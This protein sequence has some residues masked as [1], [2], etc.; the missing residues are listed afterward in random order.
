MRHPHGL[1]CRDCMYWK[2]DFGIWTMTGWT[3]MG[4]DAGHCYLEPKRISKPGSDFCRHWTDKK[5]IVKEEDSEE[6]GE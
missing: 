1:T 6:A 5:L 2:Q 3:G 4:R